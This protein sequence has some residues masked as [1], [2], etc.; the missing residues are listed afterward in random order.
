MELLTAGRSVLDD[1]DSTLMLF[2][3][4]KTRQAS[5]ILTEQKANISKKT[6]ILKGMIHQAEQVRRAI[7]SHRIESIGPLLHEGWKAKCQL[8][9]AVTNHEMN[10]IYEKALKAGALG[11]KI[12]GAGGGGFLL[13]H[14]PSNNRQRIRQVLSN[15]REMP[16]RLERGG[17]RVV[18][19][20]RRY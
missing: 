16:F 17:S 20:T 15:L 12:S 7:E 9:N 4:G 18:L 11:G 13:L 19:S 3:T 10:G 1:I 8:A 2:F 14:V 6:E 5:T